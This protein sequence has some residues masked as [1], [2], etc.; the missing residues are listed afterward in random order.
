MAVGGAA[1]GRA[2]SPR[3]FLGLGTLGDALGWDDA[4]LWRW[5]VLRTNLVPHLDS[6]M[7]APGR[8]HLR[9]P[10]MT[11]KRVMDGA[12]SFLVTLTLGTDG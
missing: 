6:E 10:P 9:F 11:Q 8:E 7:W 3:I 4:R 2:F 12:P 5:F 1:I